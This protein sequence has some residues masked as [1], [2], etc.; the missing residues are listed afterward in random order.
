[1]TQTPEFSSPEKKLHFLAAPLSTWR[2]IHGR[3][4]TQMCS[5]L[6]IAVGGP[7]NADPCASCIDCSPTV[8]VGVSQSVSCSCVVPKAGIKHPRRKF[9]VRGTDRY[10][11]AVTT[12][13]GCARRQ[14]LRRPADRL[15]CTRERFSRAL[16]SLYG[17]LPPSRP[18]LSA[19]CSRLNREIPLFALRS[20][21]PQE[22]PAFRI[23]F[24]STHKTDFFVAVFQSTCTQ[25]EKEA[26]KR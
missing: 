26:S 20:V 23:C 3:R 11:A 2:V 10:W 7:V 9:L 21:G 25:R 18:V 17:R 22:D 19:C 24:E 6:W 12:P 15:Q 8:C 14:R 4:G 16:H 13:S 1:M 5:A